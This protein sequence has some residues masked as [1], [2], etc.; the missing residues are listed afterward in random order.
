VNDMITD[1]LERGRTGHDDETIQEVADSIIDLRSLTQ[2]R[3]F[4]NE[5]PYEAINYEADDNYRKTLNIEYL[6][7]LGRGIKESGLQQP[8]ALIAHDLSAVELRALM[9]N[10]QDA[11][12]NPQLWKG[13][14]GVI[15]GNRR[16]LS[17][18]QHTDLTHEGA[19]IYPKEIAPWA[20]TINLIENMDRE[21][22]S[23]IEESRGLVTEINERFSGVAS[24]FAKF[25][26]RS[27]AEVSRLLNIGRACEQSEVFNEIVSSAHIKDR[28]ALEN[29]AQAVLG[30][31]SKHR[32][33]RINAVIDDL[34]SVGNEV[35][36]IREKAKQ[37]K[38][39]ANGEHNK[40]PVIIQEETTKADSATETPKEPA[41]PKA[42]NVKAFGK[43]LDNITL[44]FKTLETSAIDAD[45]REYAKNLRQELDNLGL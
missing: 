9:Q 13:K 11:L 39:Y 43:Q 12:R 18:T 17:I 30:D 40:P 45:L 25:S 24:K 31:Q 44:K 5:F 1:R 28:V 15:F 41:K 33:K 20:S 8:I 4:I 34:R 35:T 26:G 7:E 22:V 38:T 14:I 6:K 3:V 37:L 36:S 32:E 23:L 27:S 42:F 21:D 29:I 16:Y 19:L 2:K 10:G